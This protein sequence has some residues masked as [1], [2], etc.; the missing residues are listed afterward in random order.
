MSFD[1]YYS[2]IYLPAHKKKGTRVMHFLGVLVTINWF[3]CSLWVNSLTMFVLTPL[4]IYPFAW[5]SHWGIEHNEPL[6]WTNAWWAKRSDFRMCYELA[7]G[8]LDWGE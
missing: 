2:E 8:Q 4:M 3:I 7:T 6:A 5:F 1:E